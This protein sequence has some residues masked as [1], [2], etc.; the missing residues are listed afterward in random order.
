MPA[1]FILIPA[2]VIGLTAW[3]AAWWFTRQNQRAPRDEIDRLR[4]YA[5][6]LE[7]RLDIARSERWDRDMIVSLSDQLGTA[8]AQLAR[9]RRGSRRPTVTSA[10]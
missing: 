3:L 6:W 5:L 4:N 10:R 1:T 7:Q 2:L 8:C 9:A